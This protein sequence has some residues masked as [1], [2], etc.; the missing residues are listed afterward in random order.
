MKIVSWNMQNKRDSW[1]FL[2]NRRQDSE[3]A[4]VREACTPTRYLRKYAAP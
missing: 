1:Q 2:V 3:V 4:F